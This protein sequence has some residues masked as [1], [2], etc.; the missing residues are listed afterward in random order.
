MR[1]EPLLLALQRE[2]ILIHPTVPMEN[3]TKSRLKDYKF[4]KPR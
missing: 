2:L 1:R 4:L 3:K